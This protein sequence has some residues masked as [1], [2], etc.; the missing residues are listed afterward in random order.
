MGSAEK[1]LVE[2]EK[3]A[4]SIEENQRV[5]QNSSLK[6]APKEQTNLDELL[7]DYLVLLDK[8]ST[9]QSS[10]GTAFTKVSGL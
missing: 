10:A 1:D 4:G 3:D 8:Y 2:L 5:F 6:E 9:A 7:A